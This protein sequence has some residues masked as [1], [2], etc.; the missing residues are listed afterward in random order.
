MPASPILIIGAGPTGLALGCEL[1]WRGV[2]LR[3]VDRAEGPVDESR[4]LGVHS[5][6]LELLEPHATSEML[7][8]GRVLR[9]I[10]VY[11][12]E[13]RIARMDTAEIDSAYAQ[14]LSLP[15]SETERILVDRLRQFGVEVEWRTEAVALEQDADRVRV[16]LRRG[17]DDETLEVPWVAGCDGARSFVR[18]ALGLAFEGEAYPTAFNIADLAVDLPLDGDEPHV[19]LS[20]EGVLFF[21][22]LPEPGH[23]RVVASEARGSATEEHP[24]PTLAD[25]DRWLRQRAGPEVARRITLHEPTW[26]S[27]FRIH[28]RIVPAMRSGR[29]LLA[30]DAAHV[31]SPAGAQ[32]MNAGIYDAVNLGWKLALV[33]TSRADAALLDSYHAERHPEARA[34]LR[35]THWLTR[36]ATLEH[37]VAHAV[38]VLVTRTVFNRR[39]VARRIVREI[40]GTEVHYRGS[41]IVAGDS[42]SFEGL[43]PRDAP[44]PGDRAPDVSTA[45]G[46]LYDDLGHPGHT[47]LL[48]SAG[49]LDH[50]HAVGETVHMRSG[51]EVRPLVATS[52]AVRDRYC[53]DIFPL[54]LI[55]PDR[56]VGFRGQR[57]A[58]EPVLDHLEATLG[59]YSS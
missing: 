12:G 56:H 13:R 10:N 47:L 42:E 34:I 26:A 18:D 11:E 46:W 44:Q 32:G 15:Q 17:E 23:F 35:G 52:G 5:R 57:L 40:S 6:T 22:P 50:A 58:A 39:F 25:L 27:R 20:T 16:T 53:G 36:L 54:Y 41:P 30:G 31:H 45:P 14:V 8:R 4:A 29:V 28:R 37:P 21:I 24:D 38:R 59:R 9:A 51:G 19:F 55:R 33:A 49:D 2:A 43:Q 1:A 3:I 7:G 48:F